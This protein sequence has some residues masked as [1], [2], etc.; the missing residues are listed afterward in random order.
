MASSQD[1]KIDE[2]ESFLEG[3]LLIALPGMTDERFAQT[4]IYMCAHSAKG[5]MG[6]VINKP[7]PGLS[8]AE[9][10]K[11][12]QIDTKPLIGEFPILYG[13][14][15]ETGR[16]FVLH[17]GDYEGSDSTLPVSEDISLTATLD[18]LRAL[19]EGR[20][21]KQ[22]LFALGYAGWAPGQVET[23]FQR[24]G[25]LH[26]KADPSLVFGV[27]PEAKWRTALQRLG[28]GPSGLVADAGRA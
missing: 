21:P 25:W 10:L 7:I 22:A 16:G 1:P 17:S 26:C 5:A 23:E 18:I 13:G 9:V 12:L 8:F 6:I 15:V 19:A 2:G 11:Q 27:D 3:K 24:N 20:G 4:V 14:P 28:I